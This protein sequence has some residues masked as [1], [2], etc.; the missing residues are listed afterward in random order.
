[1]WRATRIS[2]DAAEKIQVNAGLLLK[3]FDVENPVEP[4]DDDI[5]CETTDDF[6]FSCVPEIQDLLED[7]NN[8][9]RGAKEAALITGWTCSLTFSSISIT[10][11]TLKMALGA[12]DSNNSMT[13]EGVL[14]RNNFVSDDFKK[15]YWLGDMVD[16]SKLLVIEMDN[17]LSTGGLVYTARNNGKGSLSL[18]LT[19]HISLQNPEKIPMTFYILSKIR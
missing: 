15:I 13:A 1:M 17:T 9:P 5:V 16:D 4:D 2:A 3:N 19:P 12:S 8:A 7:V 18:T 11:D 10:L 6:S 14:P